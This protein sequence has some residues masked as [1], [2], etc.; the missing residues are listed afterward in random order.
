M[1]SCRASG[2][3]AVRYGTMKEVVK[4]LTAVLS[5]GKIVRTGGS[6]KARKSSSGYDL[7]SLLV[8]SEGTLGVITEIQLKLSGQPE[9]ISS[10]VCSFATLE[11]AVNSVVDSIHAG[12]PV[13]RVELLDEIQVQAVNAYS[14]MNI[15][16]VPT[17]FFEFH[18][19][20]ASVEEQ[21]ETVGCIV[22]DHGGGSFKWS[23]SSEERSKLWEARHNAYYAALALRPKCKC[24]IT[25]V[26]VPISKLR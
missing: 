18:G 10:A 15:E 3:N 11:G 24:V 16:E 4:G 26:A 23:S 14:K 13:A 25:D 8:G 7:T 2:T 9:A 5:G 21:A 20:H 12:I 6:G 19:S 1:A 17:L 22:E